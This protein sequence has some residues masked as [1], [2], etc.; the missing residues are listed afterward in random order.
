[1]EI[2]WTSKSAGA[3]CAEFNCSDDDRVD[4]GK[5]HGT[6]PQAGSRSGESTVGAM[7]AAPFSV[8]KSTCQCK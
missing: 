8:F 3:C 5:W 7:W 4:G 6:K 1:M 2:E